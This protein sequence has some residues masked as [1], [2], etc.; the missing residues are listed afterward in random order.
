MVLFDDTYPEKPFSLFNT[1][2]LVSLSLI[3]LLCLLIFLFPAFIKRKKV[4]LVIRWLL[5]LLMTANFISLYLWTSFYSWFDIRYDL[6][7]ELCTI[8]S[9]LTLI[10]L[11]L[12]VQKVFEINYFLAIAGGIPALLTPALFRYNFPH[13]LFIQFFIDHG[14][15]VIGPLFIGAAYNLRLTKLSIIKALVTV[16][17]IGIL[18]FG[19]NLLTG[20]NYM[21]LMKKPSVPTLFDY[22]GPWP[23]YLVI[24]EVIALAAFVLLFLFHKKFIANWKSQKDEYH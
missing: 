18:V 10:M 9:I 12:P 23:W 4:R 22:L 24:C 1:P 17:V 5:A 16:N 15:L 14:L 20:A 2:H 11:I 13:F 7:L 3:T 21:F 8:T 19:I 6:P